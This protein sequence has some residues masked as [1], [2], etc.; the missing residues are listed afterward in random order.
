[1]T[2]SALQ[3]ERQAQK[4]DE[5]HGWGVGDAWGYRRGAYRRMAEILGGVALKAH[6]ETWAREPQHTR[7]IHQLVTPKSKYTVPMQR[8]SAA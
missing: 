1:M 6:D 7:H 8:I 5:M 4:S 2:N 3:V